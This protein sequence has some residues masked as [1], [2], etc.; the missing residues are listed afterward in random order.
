MNVNSKSLKT[1]IWENQLLKLKDVIGQTLYEQ[2][3]QE[4]FNKQANV[5]YVI[6][7]SI[8]TLLN[9]YI[10]PYLTYIVLQ[11]WIVSNNYK[12]TNKGVLKL[13]DSTA[14]NLTS[15]ELEYIKDQYDNKAMA[16]KSALIGY[17]KK[18]GL[19]TECT[20]TDITT[21]SIGWYLF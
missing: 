3:L 6:P 7:E 18:N 11:D 16:F 20:D 19:I 10:Q 13:N 8:T 12:L 5:D 21:E 2:V 1:L 14:S 9:D 4:V 17:L 15:S